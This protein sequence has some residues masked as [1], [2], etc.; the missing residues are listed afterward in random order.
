MPATVPGIEITDHGHPAGVGGP[1]RESHAIQPLESLPVRSQPPPRVVTP[2]AAEAGERHLRQAAREGIGIKPG[3]LRPV[4]AAPAQA[5]WD[6]YALRFT[7]PGKEV[8][9]AV[10]FEG[11]VAVEPHVSGVRQQG[12][13]QEVIADAVRSQNGERVTVAGRGKQCVLR[14]ILIEQ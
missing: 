14:G 10:A 11:N 7:Q 2:A 13:H 5:V 9:A 6:R 12:N 8:G 4:A 3:L 1:D